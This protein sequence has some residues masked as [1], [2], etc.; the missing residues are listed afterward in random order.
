MNLKSIPISSV[1]CY[2]VLAVIYDIGTNIII[3]QNNYL[4]CCNIVARIHKSYLSKYI[5]SSDLV[6]RASPGDG[7]ARIPNP[8]RLYLIFKHRNLDIAPL[9]IRCNSVKCLNIHVAGEKH[10]DL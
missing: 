7:R 3:I 9:M 8:V 4:Q 10:H 2:K 1:I 5:H 6:V